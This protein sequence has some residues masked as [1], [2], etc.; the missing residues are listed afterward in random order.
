[1]TDLLDD[2]PDLDV[3]PGPVRAQPLPA[4]RPVRWG[5]L[6]TGKIATAFVKDL[7]LL[8]ECEVAAVGARRQESADAFAAEHGI[9]RAYGDYRALVEDPDV[10]VVYVATPHAL[11]REHVELA[12]AA[13]KPV[14]CEKSLTL[15]AADAEHLVALARERNLF[16]MEAMWMR[17]NPLVRRVQQ[18]IAS[19]RVG[20]VR[21]VRADLGF[22]VDKPPTDRLHDPALG[23]GVLLDMGI[24]AVTFASLFLGEPSD[25]AATAALSELGADLNLAVSLGYPTGAVASL[26]STMT[27]WSPRT[28]SVAT[29]RGRFDFPPGFHHPRSVTWTTLTDDPDFAGPSEP[30]ELTT[31]LIG[32]GLSLEA[33][34]VVRCLRSGETESPLV[35]LDDTVALMAQMDR[36]RHLVGVRYDVD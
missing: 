22:V 34:E 13:G 2:L 27:A 10:D 24:Y 4:D 36:I 31:E 17:C 15:N 12:F 16:F 30:Q 1:V 8:E 23:A 7:A 20:E 28:A 11:H 26:T 21:Q 3:T 18:L 33:L 29:D 32:T 6:A 19:G 9:A 5:I 25:V 35:P 14:L